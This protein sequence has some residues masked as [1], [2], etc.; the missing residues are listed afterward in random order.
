MR[1]LQWVCNMLWH[2]EPPSEAIQS[3]ALANRITEKADTLRAHLSHYQRSTDP[4]AA[5]MADL[6]NRDQIDRIWRGPSSD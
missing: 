2:R 6:W 5:M 3:K 4:F 1:V